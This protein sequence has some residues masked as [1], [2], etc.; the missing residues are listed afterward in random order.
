MIKHWWSDSSG[1]I[2]LQ[3]TSEDVA[4]VP[5]QGAADDAVAWLQTQPHIAA[6]LAKVSQGTLIKVLQ[7]YGAWDAT[8]LADRE[9]NERRILWLAAGDISD[10]PE[11]EGDQ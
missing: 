3:L 2:E 4:A 9:Q 6:Q 5:Q 1:F 10:N 7:E 11:M 8:E